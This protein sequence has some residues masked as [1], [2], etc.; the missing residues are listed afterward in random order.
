MS[1]SGS[2]VLDENVKPGEYVLQSLF[3]EFCNLSEKKIELVLAEPLVCE[4]RSFAE[5]LIQNY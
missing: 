2:P 3:L 4:E 1:G 5:F